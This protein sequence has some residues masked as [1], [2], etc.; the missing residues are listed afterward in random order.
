MK[1]NFENLL[2]FKGRSLYCSRA[3]L[4]VDPYK[5]VNKAI[6]T[7]AHFDH[8]SFGCHEYI[9]S[10]ETSLILKE[11]LGNKIN[12]K[13][14]H[15]GEIFKVNGVSIS[16][17]PSGHIIG[18]SQIRFEASGVVWLVTGDFKTQDDPTCLGLERIKTDVLICES[19]F[20]LPI[21][22]W[23]KTDLI[24][25]NI[26]K[27]VNDYPDKTSL[28]FCYTLGKA[29]R[30]LNEIKRKNIKKIFTHKSISKINSCYKKLGIDIIDTITFEK[31]NFPKDTLGSLVLLPPSLNTKKFIN[32]IKNPQ[33]SFASGWMTIRALK[34]RSGYEKGFVISDHADWNGLINTIKESKAKKIYLNHGD[35]E[36]LA[37]YLR[38]KD[39][40]D[41]TAIKNI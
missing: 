27:W 22:N 2:D 4:W 5:P 6:V 37:E 13:T 25:N 8:L 34:K 3:D 17:F 32:S 20:S 31:N 35:G 16:L 19:T 40:L 26:S 1:S 39:K 7:H 12:I 18:S 38:S 9:C 30:I 24:A 14:Y 10:Y 23:E 15:Y 33:T 29:Q 21:F 36:N 41:I 28:L 11:R